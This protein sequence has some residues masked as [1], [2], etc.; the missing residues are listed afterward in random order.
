M[1][2]RLRKK[3]HRG[4]FIDWNVAVTVNLV[5]GS[6]Y[7]IFLDDWIEQSI[8]GNHCFF[9]GS[10]TPQ[11]IEGTIQLGTAAKQPE[12]RLTDIIDWL[13]NRLDVLNFQFSP[14]YDG[15]NGPFLDSDGREKIF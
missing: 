14:L 13:N 1:R 2:K 6:D 10:S 5:P 4:E 8:E 7:E 15:W 12:K 9:G 3:K 11:Q